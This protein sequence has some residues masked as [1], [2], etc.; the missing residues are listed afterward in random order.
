[1]DPFNGMILIGIFTVSVLVWAAYR[2]G[3]AFGRSEGV[4]STLISQ[5]EQRLEELRKNG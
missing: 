3:Y 1:M 4:L 2:L 5:S